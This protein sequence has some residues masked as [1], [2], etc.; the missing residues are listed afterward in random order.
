MKARAP[1]PPQAPQ[2][3]PRHIFRNTVPDGGGT[4][5]MDAKE[6]MLRS[7]V[8]LQLTLP[9]GYQT[10]VTEEGSKALMDLLVELCSRYHLNP[11]L[12]TLELLSPEGHPL[13]FKPN[14]LLGSLNVACVLIKE[15]VWE[16]KVVRRPAP[17][18]PEKTVRLMVNYH[19]SQKAVVRVNPLVPLQA[20]TPVI[21]DKCEFDPAYV[22]LLK[23]SISRHRLPLDKSLTELGIKEL[24]VHDQ[25]LVLQPKMASAPA[26][27]YSDSI[28]SS[29]TS[30]GRAEKKS[31]LG[32]FQLSRG[33]SKTETTS[34]DMDD[35]DEKVIQNTDTQSNGLSTVSRIPSVEDR[36]STL[37][38]S[39]SVMN[40][41]KMSPKAEIKKRRAP[42]P[43]ETPT[44]IMGHT[45]FEGYQM[46]LGSESQQRKRK[47]PA[48]PPTPAS[49][50]PG[51]DETSTS[52]APTPDS[53]AT[54]TP[55][56]AFRTKVAQSIPVS[57]NIVV[58]QTVKPVPLKTAV[59][60]ATRTASSPTPSSSTADS[61]AAQDSSSELSHSLDYS[62]ADLDQA[63]SHCSTL[64][65]STASGS[66]RVQPATKSSSS[67]MEES[68]E[69]ISMAAK[70]NQE[71]SSASSPRLETESALN[72][73][74]DEVENN[75][76]STM[77]WLHSMQSSAASGQKADTETPE[78]ETLSLGSS[79]S[80]GTSLPDQFYAASEGMAE[81]EDSGMVSSPSD[82][83]PTSPEGS[84]SLDGSS[85]GGGERLLGPVR[86]NSSDSD[87]GCATWGSRHR[88]ND[89]TPQ[90][91]S[92]MLKDSYEDQPELTAQLHQTLADFEA[93]LADHIDIVS[94]KENPYTI[95]T[96]S[97]EVPVSVVDMDVPV[98]AIDEVMED[99]ERNIVENEAKSLTRTDSAGSK[100]PCFCHQSSTEPQNK[101]NNAYTAA[102]SN[103]SSSLNT[104]QLSQLEQ[105]KKSVENKS[106]GDKTE[107]KI[108]EIKI[109]EMSITDTNIVKEDKEKTISAVKS[110]VNMQKHNKSTEIKPDPVESNAQSFQE[111]K[112]V[113]PPTCQ[114]SVSTERAEEMHRIYENNS[115]SN[116]SH[117]KVTRN[118]TS[119]FGMNT[120]TVVPP[121]P[122][123]MH[124][125]TGDS[126]VSLTAGAIK[127]DD[128]GNIVEEGISWKKV[129]GSSESTN[130]S[131]EGSSLLGKAKAFWSSNERQESAV[132]HSKGQ[133]NKAKENT[134][135]LRS[136]P[137]VIS[138]TVRK[139]SNT[140]YLK[141]THSVL[142]KPAERAQPKEM[143]KGE[144]KE[145]VNDIHV[146]KEEQVEVE[147]KISVS[148]NIQQPSNK[149]SLP[150]PILPDL[151]RDLSFLKPSRRTSSHYVASAITKYTPKTSAKPSSI[152]NVPDSSA[153]V[154]TQ[155]IGFQRSG[156]SIQVNP[157]QSSHSSL[158]DNKEND[159]AYK[160]NPSGPKRFKSYPE[161]VSGSQR[162]FGEVR[163]DTGGFACCVGS[164][165]GS[166]NMLET[167][168]AKNTHIQSSG[169]TQLNVT[170]KN[171]RDN[172]K[173][174]WPRSPNPAQSSPLHSSAKP[175]TAPKSISQGQTSNTRDMPK[176]ATHPTPD[177]IPQPSVKLSDREDISGPVTVFGPVKKFRPVIC[178]SV[179][180]ET[181]LHSSLME[182][183]QTGGGR[184]RLKK[185]STSG[186]GSIKKASYVEE[187][188]ERSALL[189]AIRAQSNSGGL[190]KTKSEAADELE[191]FRKV[192]SEEERSVDPPSS[193]SPPYLTSTS[194]PVFTP[195]LAPMVA[196]P[197]PPPV[198]PQGKP[199]TLAH[200]S[201]NTP[202][203]P[204]LARE[205][206]LETIRSGSAAERLKKCQCT[207]RYNFTQRN[208]SKKR[209]KEKKRDNLKIG[210]DRTDKSLVSHALPC[211]NTSLAEQSSPAMQ[212]TG[213]WK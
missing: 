41:T 36:P 56:P 77:A 96:D 149:S 82:T 127:I 33:K 133:I 144:A 54:E 99:Y 44:P 189:V 74:L 126:A 97:T 27:N 19:G 185:I 136:T 132:P 140:E 139:T 208:L 88:H 23:D 29:T 72:L 180:K 38:Q 8:D 87:E 125:A 155:T 169:P 15:K 178:R 71:V 137:T 20:L 70:L 69:S 109:K 61:I 207:R 92:G 173:H 205:A 118:V 14:A 186:P 167:E 111:K 32:I 80:G 148:R 53:H 60:P 190:R 130:Y 157:H 58:M 131:S 66:V 198:L 40:M 83:Q 63:S 81:G 211:W 2:P 121:K 30:L 22:L 13:G 48:P 171:D 17:K 177:V 50:T 179:E 145:Q 176:T 103:K 28:C 18:V 107:D 98:T 170:A 141:T 156:R 76:H 106:I 104:K 12:H 75:R 55:T 62:D 204:A 199:S 172:I 42:A 203:N 129:G 124:A 147:N 86:E 123:V 212:Q 196:P 90:A 57:S 120:F 85:G 7:T 165:K 68:E 31:F 52:A 154:K 26:L 138:E 160:P 116:T 113:L 25:S 209:G 195:P 182:A 174:I 166:S 21:C 51:S 194:P 187:D 213:S 46:G 200:P 110:N 210:R 100:G 34:V 45:S 152:P 191:K 35:C 117:G 4:S 201:A 122:S 47:A 168:T 49:I 84:L 153:S 93:D 24:Y 183:I 134:D 102:D 67:R 162:D 135:G 11:A 10:S 192:A 197:T 95:S 143:V 1:P 115:S 164:T 108:I 188:N 79:S 73:K 112:P 151:T 114:R 39:Q 161:Y 181:S 146:A 159:A 9:E 43:P 158:S 184:D 101:N 206:M 163:P 3:A 94:A 202:M 64:T 37:G 16:E 175:P 142:N 150:P 128:Q 65:S 119:R 78:E 89:I 91:K 59:Q 5:G 193:P 105:H 6:N